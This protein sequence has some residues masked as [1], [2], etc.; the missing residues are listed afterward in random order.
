MAS[1]SVVNID[2]LAQPISADK[3][4][5]EDLRDDPS[6]TSLYYRIKDARSSARAAERQAL[7]DP[8][9]EPGDWG[10]ILD[11]VPQ[12]LAEHTK[13]LELT[14]WYIE[15]LVREYGFAGLRDGFKLARRLCETY[16]D[17][18]YPLP[19]EDGLIARVSALSGLNGEE[20]EGTLIGPINAIPLTEHTSAGQFGAWQY[21][22]ALEVSRIEDP[23]KRKLRIDQGAATLEEFERAVSET[24]DDFFVQLYED[25]EQAIDAFH[26]YTQVLDERCG[27]DSPPSSAILGALTNCRDIVRAVAKDVL[28]REALKHEAEQLVAETEESQEPGS[29]AT[30]AASGAVAVGDVRNR[31]DALRVLTQISEFFRR[32]EPH[33]PITYLLQ[34]AVRW[35]RTPLPDLL[36]ELIPD[37][38]V[39]GTIFR[40]SG[41]PG[42]EA[43]GV[44]GALPPLSMEQM[45]YPQSISQAPAGIAAPQPPPQAAPEP[46]PKYED[47]KPW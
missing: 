26:G 23:D 42:E 25:I 39:R 41:I 5:G 11:L 13:D 14:A 22:Q 15:A 32:N 24:P 1:P 36:R 37:P 17:D 6:P 28:D 16:F 43:E 3:P 20:A 47:E 33:T 40:L 34:Q 45:M 10:P 27:S 19:D 44:T 38:S 30:V 12:C 4:V 31:E 2:E 8:D 29:T 7:I 46:A 35:G 18:I 9:A 21:Q